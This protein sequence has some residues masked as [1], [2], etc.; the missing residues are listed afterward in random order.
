V[1]KPSRHGLVEFDTSWLLPMLV[2]ISAPHLRDGNTYLFRTKDIVFQPQ[3]SS[4]NTVS[5]RATLAL[6]CPAG[7]VNLCID[8][9]MLM[10]DRECS[11][12]RRKGQ[13]P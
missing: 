10:V 9:D 7:K 1:K 3:S 4:V 2:Y 12:W 13:R 11:E 6:S 5:S 8:T